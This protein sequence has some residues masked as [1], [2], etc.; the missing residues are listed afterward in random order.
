M[1]FDNLIPSTK[2]DLELFLDDI[3]FLDALKTIH[4][5]HLPYLADHYMSCNFN[6]NS[7]NTEDLKSYS[8][9]VNLSSHI[10]SEGE[11]SLL[12]KGLTF[13]CTPGPPDMGILFE[14]LEKFHRSIKRNIAIGKFTTGQDTQLNQPETTSTPF[15][16]TKFKNPSNWNPPG[17]P[18]L[19]YMCFMNEN[20]LQNQS[21]SNHKRANLRKT[22]FE[23]LKSLKNNKDIVIKKA[24]KGSAVVIQNRTDY[25]KEG[26]KQLND[27]K[28][29]T[30]VESDLTVHHKNLVASKINTMF[31][32]GEIDQKCANYLVIDNPRT[33]NFYLLPKIHKGKLPPPGRPIVSANEC[34][35]ERI[36]QFVDHFI[37]P[38]VPTLKSY[39]KDSG[40]FLN[41][42]NQ[43]N[44][45]GDIILCTLDVTSLYTNIP[46]DEG[47]NAVR[48]SLSKSRDYTQNPTNNSI[49]E[50]L[51]LVL[52]CNNFQFDNKH[53]LQIGGTAMGTKVAPSFANIF[54]GWFEDNFVYTYKLQ[55]ILW[56][57]YIDDIFMIWQHGDEALKSFVE[58]LN[59][60]HT[61]IKFTEETSKSSVN[62]LDITVSLNNKQE[63]TTSL[64]TKPT[65]SHNYLLYSS[66]HPRHLLRGIPYSQFLRVRRICSSIVD[67][68]QHA[69]T[70]ASHFIR[71]GYPKYL[72]KNALTRAELQDRNTLLN[73]TRDT[74]T[75]DNP[76]DK[77]DQSFYLVV[78]HN[79]KNPPLRDIV[80]DNWPLLN[81]SKT[82]RTL[83]DVNI[84]FG[85]RRNKNLSDYLI[86]ASTKTN[87]TDKKNVERNPCQRPTKCRY[88][89]II[90]KTGKI[91]SH[92]TG[93]TFTTL[94]SVNCQSSNLIYA[95]TCNN[96]GIQY[97]GQTK[98]RL[99]TRFQGHFNDITH[100]R[101]TTVARH[102][103]RCET[104]L[105]NHQTHK[106]TGQFNITILSFIPAPP[107]TVESK[108]HRD[109]E[110]KRW[111]H[112]LTTI[113]PSGLNLMD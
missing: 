11:Q 55:P 9:V 69:L 72:V 47:I 57:R 82:T 61:S 34:P 51:S 84:T 71:R 113:M 22:E 93:K 36:S 52:K 15:K 97:V 26:L 37:Q 45:S 76:S 49:C 58:H 87:N 66:E 105:Q 60:S 107:D 41:I 101:D 16:H 14:D 64:Y 44:P 1:N 94:K 63:I 48:Q 13:V 46:N 85:L 109:K 62:F 18:I 17:P 10:L 3:D 53:Y 96:C 12:S 102:L 91:K 43:V 112:R 35:T 2:C 100:D 20:S 38:I 86:R 79:P 29:Y 67:F 59:Q 70:L 56:K 68:R 24:D 23:A 98:N 19:E 30:Q 7:I 111:M 104:R 27:T 54:M 39:I 81:K 74:T 103:N 78:T 90:N 110:E 32:S 25:I 80:Y 4:F 50:L 65:D 8:G 75:K 92:S 89:P 21:S 77:N 5:D 28:F 108:L 33:A 88:C 95:I 99:M 73:K 6:S 40:H 83:A 42:L 31:T 106:T